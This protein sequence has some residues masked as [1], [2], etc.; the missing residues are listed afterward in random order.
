MKDW[1]E[2]LEEARKRFKENSASIISRKE[3]ENEEG[4][5][6][7]EEEVLKVRSRV[8]MISVSRSL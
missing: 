5:T 4:N 1:E 2:K 8:K 7:S 6:P 3:T